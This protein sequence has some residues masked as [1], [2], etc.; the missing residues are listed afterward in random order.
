MKILVPNADIIQGLRLLLNEE[1][2]MR[3]RRSIEEGWVG[4][5]RSKNGKKVSIFEN[6]IRNKIQVAV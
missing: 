4:R 1:L 6:V 3:L 2:N 5:T